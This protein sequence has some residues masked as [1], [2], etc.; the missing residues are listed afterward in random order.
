MAADKLL[1]R[2][3]GKP[4]Q[5]VKLQAELGPGLAE[6]VRQARERVI[7]VDAKPIIEHETFNTKSALETK[8]VSPLNIVSSVQSHPVSA[9]A[10]GERGR[11]SLSKHW[12]AAGMSRAT[13][14]RRRNAG[15]ADAHS[16]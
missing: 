3:W 10:T 16:A 13:W 7:A 11:P 2:G 1:D 14:F 8:S 5:D 15:K 9:I 4:S 6:I 12:E